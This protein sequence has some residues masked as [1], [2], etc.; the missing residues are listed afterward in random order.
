MAALCD[1]YDDRERGVAES[2]EHGGPGEDERQH[3]GQEE[4]R[5]AEREERSAAAQAHPT[6][7]SGG[8][9]EIAM[10]TAA[11]PE[12]WVNLVLSQLNVVQAA[13]SQLNKAGM[14]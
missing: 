14:A 8:T 4:H 3:V 6:T 13:L 7:T 2:G 11:R 9:S 12:E 10:A 1:L 5:R